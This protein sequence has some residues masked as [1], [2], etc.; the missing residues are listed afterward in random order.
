[1]YFRG[2]CKVLWRSPEDIQRKAVFV[3]TVS[4]ALTAPV[5][6]NKREGA[7]H[8]PVAS[9]WVIKLPWHHVQGIEDTLSNSSQDRQVLL[10]FSDELTEA[11]KVTH[12]SKLH[13]QSLNP[14]LSSIKSF[15]GSG[16]KASIWIFCLLRLC[17]GK[18]IW[19]FR[20]WTCINVI[21]LEYSV[22]ALLQFFF[23]SIAYL[24]N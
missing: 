12:Y 2:H 17:F 15:P 3:R 1:M 13:R 5:F 7:N 6:Y 22:I 14:G 9:L 24:A 11:Q 10:Y 4:P 23:F 21:L 8:F 19:T 16:K 20:K 18:H